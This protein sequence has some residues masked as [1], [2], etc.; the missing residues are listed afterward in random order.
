MTNVIVARK[1]TI[2]VSANATAGV[3]DSSNP[4][5]LK[6]ISVLSSAASSARLD[7]LQDVNASTE[8]DGATLVYNANNDTYDV[9][10]LDLAN[11]TGTLDGGIF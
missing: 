8:T 9:K 1:R 3:I 10:K 5:V 6:P 11:V 4:V 7:H 2:Q